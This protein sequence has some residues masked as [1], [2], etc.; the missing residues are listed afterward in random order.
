MKKT[1]CI[2]LCSALLLTAACFPA[3]AEAA[4]AEPNAVSVRSEITADFSRSETDIR[5]ADGDPYFAGTNPADSSRYLEYSDIDYT[6]AA[7]SDAAPAAITSDV[8]H[9]F[10]TRYQSYTVQSFSDLL[11]AEVTGRYVNAG[12]ADQT[13]GRRGNVIVTMADSNYRYLIELTDGEIDTTSRG[14]IEKK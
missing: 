11:Y 10:H 9:L 1:V 5:Q 6:F 12:G 3:Y 7:D 14:R 8:S 13:F 2:I 4:K